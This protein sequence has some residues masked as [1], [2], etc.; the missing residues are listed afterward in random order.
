MAIHTVILYHQQVN[1]SDED[2]LKKTVQYSTGTVQY[3]N[4]V[5]LEKLDRVGFPKR[6]RESSVQYCTVRCA[7]GLEFR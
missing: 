6:G 1:D 5:T 7:A 3:S 4:L 2:Q